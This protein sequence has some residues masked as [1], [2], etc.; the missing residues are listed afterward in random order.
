MVTGISHRSNLTHP[1]LKVTT[2]QTPCQDRSLYIVGGV[3]NSERSLKINNPDIRTLECALLERMYY[4]KVGGEFVS[5]PV[6]DPIVLKSRLRVFRNKLLRQIGRATKISPEQF[7]QMY[8]GRKRTIYEAA[9]AE[10]YDRG[11]LR[12]HSVSAAFVKCEKVPE[13]KAPRC[14]QPRHPVYNVGLGCYLKHIEHRIY[15]AIGRV[16]G[17][18]VTVVKGFNVQQ[19]ADLLVGKW[20][21]FDDPVA[22]GLDAKS[23]D[24]HVSKAMLEWEHSIY[25]A[26]H[27]SRMQL[28]NI[29]AMQLVNKGVGRCADGKLRYKVDGRRFSGDMNTAL[30]NCLIMCAMVYSYARERGV[31][32]KLMN[33]G[34]DC[35]VFMERR[36][37][38]KF[39]LGLSEWFM[40]CGFRMTIED[41][42]YEIQQVEFCQMKPVQTSA[43]WVM[44]RNLDKAREKD[45]MSIIPLS[46]ERVLR[47]WMYAVGE[48]GLALC[49]GVPIMQAL[50]MNYMRQGEKSKL[51]DSVAM[52]SGARMLARG[53]DVKWQPI[54]DKA[55]LDV[56]T[57]WGYT[58]DEQIAMEEWYDSLQFESQAHAVELLDEIDHAPL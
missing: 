37:L 1:Q 4:C 17:D 34:D 28:I 14:I 16:F 15:G 22:V 50:Y 24:M 25:K 18:K 26:V 23:F 30:G 6:P 42:V 13:G 44:V 48:C 55:R 57:A 5:P 8:R 56:F 10:Y 52:Q 43:G 53:M 7:V 46:N 27:R 45:S 40:D 31:N 58:P 51:G 19:V 41:P 36:D 3:G 29:M 20:E 39:M 38:Q 21:S 11:V 32:I 2:S 54:T 35:Q 9:V 33:N 47:K 49:G 12:E